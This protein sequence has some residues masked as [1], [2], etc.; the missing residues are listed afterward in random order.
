MGLADTCPEAV[1]PA[2]VEGLQAMPDPSDP[3]AALALEAWLTAGGL[4]G[5]ALLQAGFDLPG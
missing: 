2:V 1:L 5:A 3:S 4:C